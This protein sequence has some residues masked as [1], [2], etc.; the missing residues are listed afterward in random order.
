MLGF[1]AMVVFII[2]AVV[3]WVDKSV[4]SD[5]RTMFILLFIGLA[6]FSASAGWRTFHPDGGRW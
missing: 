3:A 4:A 6:C 2:G 5:L 1:I